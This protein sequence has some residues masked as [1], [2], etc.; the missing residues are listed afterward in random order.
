MTVCLG[1]LSLP[2]HTTNPRVLAGP[3]LAFAVALTVVMDEM[4]KLFAQGAKVS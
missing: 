4:V 2:T 1:S 3:A